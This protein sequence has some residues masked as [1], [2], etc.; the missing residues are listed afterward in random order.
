MYFLQQ[1]PDGYCIPFGKKQG[2]K[3]TLPYYPFYWGDY[4]AKTFNLTQGQHGAY[5]L[6]MRHI[7]TEGTQIPVKH[8]YSIAKALLEQER[9]NVDYVLEHYFI[10]K[11]EMWVN[12]RSIEVMKEWAERHQRRVIA[13]KNRKKQSLSNLK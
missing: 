9:E 10:K 8:C 4:S 5:L 7:Y 2:R 1:K 3:M 12:N 6:L 11:G 13:G